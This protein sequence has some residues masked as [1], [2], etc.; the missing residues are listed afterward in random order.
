MRIKCKVLDAFWEWLAQAVFYTPYLDI[1]SAL[2][3]TALSLSIRRFMG[4]IYMRNS[5][6]KQI[7]SW[8][9]I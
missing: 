2:R 8:E 4:C 5:L 7:N 9:L 6:K 3:F 1:L